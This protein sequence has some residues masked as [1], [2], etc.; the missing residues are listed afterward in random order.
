MSDFRD[1]ILKHR[2]KVICV[3]GGAPFDPE[4]LKSVKADV[5][6]SANE[7]GVLAHECDYIVAM[8]DRHGELG[9]SMYDHLRA[10]SPLPIIG[11]QAFA[12]YQLSTWPDAPRRSV[13][14]G[15]TGVWV[16][17]AMGAKAVV[18]IGMNAYNGKPG[19]DKDARIVA[20]M[21]S[22][23]VRCVDGGVLE[24][25]FG[26]YDPKEKFGHYKESPQIRSLMDV[27]EMITVRVFKPTGFRGREV[28][29]G[30]EFKVMRH[31][32]KAQLKHGMLR[33]V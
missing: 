31:E 30:E 25:I 21:V 2:G 9:V 23:P 28:Q 5:F 33:E 6:I 13:L 7:H 17:W 4:L 20:G 16:A 24:E 18:T 1:L 27:D 3:I 26:A 11:P 19:A 14:S 12:D 32:V 22:V 29:K 8:D 10:Y 15:M